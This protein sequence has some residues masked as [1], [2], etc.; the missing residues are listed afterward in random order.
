[1]NTKWIMTVAAVVVMGLTSNVQ[2]AAITGHISF[3]TENG[4]WSGNTTDVNTISA[5]TSFGNVS[6]TS[7]SGSFAAI[8]PGTSV[9][10]QGFNFVTPVFNNPL[11][12]VGGYTF[13]LTSITGIT[14]TDSGID[15]LALNGN[16][17]ISNGV[18]SQFGFWAW[19]G[20][21]NGTATFSFSSTT[22]AGVP[23]GGTTVMLL[24]GALAGLG[25][26]RKKLFA[27]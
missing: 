11:W 25:L 7:G 5:I 22:V 23:D 1:M 15:T 6:V 13:S 9:T 2:A 20:E 27:V 12:S 16:G 10:M 8:L 21:L 4:T 26:L 17:N 14:R 24:G 3:S 19:S 18:D